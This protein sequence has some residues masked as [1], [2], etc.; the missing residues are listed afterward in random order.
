MAKEDQI[1]CT[2]A[3]WAPFGTHLEPL[4]HH[5]GTFWRPLGI[6][7]HLLGPTPTE[8]QL[9]PVV[10]IRCDLSLVSIWAPVGHNLGH[11]IV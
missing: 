7:W 2:L 6:L 10:V 11:Y 9:G 4:G 1:L 8:S 3:P 5:L